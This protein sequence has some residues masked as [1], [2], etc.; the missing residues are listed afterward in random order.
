ML[1]LKMLA[2]LLALTIL[3]KKLKQVEFC[4]DHK[5]KYT[6]LKDPNLS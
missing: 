1:W 4:A 5:N 6:E 2:T 3:N